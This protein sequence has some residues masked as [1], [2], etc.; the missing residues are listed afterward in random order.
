M[1]VGL[2]FISAICLFEHREQGCSP[3]LAEAKARISKDRAHYS[4]SMLNPLIRK[5]TNRRL[6]V[7]PIQ[8][9]ND[10][11]DTCVYRR[12]KIYQKNLGKK[13]I[14]F[15]MFMR[16]HGLS[17]D[18]IYEHPK[19]LREPH[20][21]PQSRLF[22]AFIKQS[23]YKKVTLMCNENKLYA[24]QI[25]SVGKTPAHWAALRGDELMLMQLLRYDAPLDL[26]DFSGLTPLSYAIK[27]RYVN[28]V[29]LLLLEKVRPWRDRNGSYTNYETDPHITK[30]L[31]ASMMV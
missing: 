6:L 3:L 29:Q 20:L 19:L 9:V 26:E 17:M 16:K 23:E 13:V 4:R 30:L 15:L 5:K 22:F 14:R 11:R 28:V 7:S 8:R 25:D 12:S 1:D 10:T 31:R 24:F 21:L 27:N 2:S 18:D